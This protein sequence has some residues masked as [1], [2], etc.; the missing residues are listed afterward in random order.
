ME[1]GSL[2]YYFSP[3]ITCISLLSVL[4]HS[5]N[6]DCVFLSNFQCTLVTFPTLIDY[7]WLDLSLELGKDLFL[8]S[9]QD[10]SPGTLVDFGIFGVDIIIF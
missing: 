9:P 5:P 6:E 2:C 3:V 10:K 1:A 4:L 8:Q 7:K